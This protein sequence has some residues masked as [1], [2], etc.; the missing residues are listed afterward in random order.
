MSDIGKGAIIIGFFS[1]LSKAAGLVR[2]RLLASTFGAGQITDAYFAAF[3]IPD[4][5]FTVLVL[6]A[7]SAAF[8]PVFIK[9]KEGEGDARAWQVAGS[10]LTILTVILSALALIAFVCA[11]LLV[12]VIAPGFTEANAELTVRLTRVMLLSVIFFGASNVMSGVLNALH[13]YAV[14]ALA[15]VLY[16]VGIIVGITIFAPRIGPLGLG[17]GVVVGALLH[18]LVQI[19]RVLQLGRGRMR[20]RWAL[21][22]AVRR[23]MALM[24]PRMLGLAAAQINT[25]VVIALASA[26]VPGSVAVYN[27][28][29][30]L[31]SFPSG[32]IGVS[33]AV[34]AFPY[35]AT[36]AARQ[37]LV[38][39]GARFRAS[40]AHILAF[41]T[42]LSVFLILLR[43]QV[44]RVLLGAGA[45]D[46]TD[47]VLT[48]NTLG[49]LAIALC[50]DGIIP[51][52]A[53]AFYAFQDTWT[54]VRWSLAAV[55]LNL[56]LALSLRGYGVEGI[57]LAFAGT[58]IVQGG[59]LAA[60]LR[61]KIPGIFGLPFAEGFVKTVAAAAGGAVVVQ[62][63]KEPIASWVN[64]DTGFGVLL[65]GAGAG[66]GG[67]V[68]YYLLARYFKCPGVP[69]MHAMNLFLRQR[70]G[71]R[72]LSLSSQG[73]ASGI[74]NKE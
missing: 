17:W 37:E 51:L 58:Q 16:N 32:V 13:R 20:L 35:F 71:V 5:I 19:P 67:M 61:K 25:V 69:S 59:L 18:L 56:A 6:G 53:R 3:K 27:F 23:V 66:L 12:R 38:E 14:L 2:E 46:W 49:L 70:M 34:A 22:P 1:V 4:F 40:L 30:N 63:L 68:V 73:R 39:F 48:A 72:G 50:A 52:L 65:Q 44:V 47:T 45:F 15:P 42:P 54:P 29:F 24:G 31:V 41:L 28:A 11:P 9:V 36:H 60:S 21:D 62:M 7:L 43:A 57:A 8:I 74:T 64:M 26:F 10:V 33:F 55:A